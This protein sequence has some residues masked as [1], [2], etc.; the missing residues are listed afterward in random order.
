MRQL[1]ILRCLVGLAAENVIRDRYNLPVVP[2]RARCELMEG[3]MRAVEPAEWTGGN[4]F[5]E[6]LDG[7]NG[8]F[9]RKISRQENRVLRKDQ[10]QPA[11]AGTEAIEGGNGQAAGE[12]G[13]SDYPCSSSVGS[14]C[15]P[16]AHRGIR[17]T[18]GDSH[19]AG[20][21]AFGFR[22]EDA[23]QMPRSHKKTRQVSFHPGNLGGGNR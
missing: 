12:R 15:H 7:F 11:M 9:D 18:A 1:L 5:L 16:C 2:Y 6:I 20:G 3:D 10:L 21:T 8:R 14:S 23:R 13:I 4:Q 17:N 22:S 19:G